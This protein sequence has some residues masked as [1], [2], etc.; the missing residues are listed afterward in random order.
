MPRENIESEVGAAE[1]P[2]GIKGVCRQ[3]PKKK[4]PCGLL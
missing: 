1:R 4:V 2:K 3:R